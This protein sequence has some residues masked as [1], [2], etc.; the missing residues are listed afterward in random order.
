MVHLIFMGYHYISLY[1]LL[2]L[3]YT[4]NTFKLYKFKNKYINLKIKINYI[5]D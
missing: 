4:M 3:L 2:F 1:H 5:K